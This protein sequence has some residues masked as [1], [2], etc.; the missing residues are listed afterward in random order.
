MIIINFYSKWINLVLTN[1]V[2]F[3]LLAMVFFSQQQE[4][5]HL[6]KSPRYQS[7]KTVLIIL[8]ILS[9]IMVVLLSLNGTIEEK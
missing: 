2:D 5:T 3:T 1:F 8:F 4:S 7:L 6:R 9:I